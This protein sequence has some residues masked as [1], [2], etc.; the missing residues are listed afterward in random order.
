VRGVPG[1]GKSVFAAST[2]K[3]LADTQDSEGRKAPVLFFFFRQIVEKNRDPKYLVR[4]WA[5]QLL[6]FS[7]VLKETLGQL[8]NES[9]VNGIEMTQLWGGLVAALKGTD[10]VYCVAD[11]LDEMDDQHA[12]FVQKLRELGMQNPKSIKVLLTSRPVPRIEAQLRH[13][14]VEA[15]RLEPAQIYPDIISYVDSRL[16]T[17]E[18][19]VSHEKE[20]Q[21]KDAICERANGLFL[22]ARLTMDSLA[23]GL[24]EG[25][26]IE[27]TLP[28][29]LEQLPR[30]LKELYTK[31]LA[32]HSKRSGISQDQQFAI[33]Q[34]VTHS[35]RP[36]RLIELGSIIALLRRDPRASFK[37]GKD[38]VR[39]ACGRLLEILED[40]SVSVIHHSITE[41]AR[42]ESRR[43]EPGAFPVLDER[44]A[45]QMM[46]QVCLEYLDS[47][48]LPKSVQTSVEADTP[49]EEEQKKNDIDAED[50]HDDDS[51][52]PYDVLDSFDNR[53][54]R[55]RA[56][57]KKHR[58][59]QELRSSY[60]LIGYATE[61]LEYHIRNV[62]NGFHLLDSY[63]TPGKNAF[64]IWILVQ[65][66]PYRRGMLK[67][68]HI[69]ASLGLTEYAQ[70]LIDTGH[71]IDVAY[72]E[73]QTALSCAVEAGHVE[74]Q[75]ALS[76]AV[77]AGHVEVASLLLSKGANPNT[78]DRL[79]Y[80]PL[81]YAA[82]HN[83]VEVSKLLLA[84]GV[85]PK[86]EKTKCTPEYIV[87]QF[88][89]DRGETPLQ[90][91]CEKG[92]TEIIAQFVEVLDVDDA[93]RCL[94]WAVSSRKPDAVEAI[95][96]TGKARV[97]AFMNGSTALIKAAD[98][99]EPG[100]IEV[101]VRYGA[102]PNLRAEND[103]WHGEDSPTAEIK[104]ASES[105]VVPTAMHAFAGIKGNDVLWGEKKP[106]VE[107]MKFLVEAGGDANA[108][109]VGNHTPLHYSV[110]KRFT[111]WGE[112]GSDKTEEIVTELLLQHGADPNARCDGGATPLHKISPQRPK[113]VDILLR[114]G[115]DI[116]A[117][118]N[119]GSTPL[120]SIISS[121]GNGW[122]D[123]T[124]DH[125][126]ELS[127]KT[128]LKLLEYGA[129][130]T[131]EDHE[132]WTVL[133]HMFAG[134]DNFKNEELWKAFIKAGADLNKPN[135]DGKPPL[136]SI[137]NS[138][139]NSTENE[140]LFKMLVEAGL[141][142]NATDSTD[143]TVLFKLFDTY[144]VE[145]SA[146]QKLLDLGCSAQAR[147]QTGATLLHRCISA[148]ADFEIFKF[149]VEAGAEPVAVDD[150][151]NTIF[152]ELATIHP[153]RGFSTKMKTLVD[154]RVPTDSQ[155]KAGMTPLH[156]ACAT[157]GSNNSSSG[158]ERTED[159][160][161]SLLN[162]KLCP[163]S[164]FNA[165]DNIRAS[166][167]HYA[168]SLSEY[169]VGRLLRAGA[170][171]TLKTHEGLIP[172]HIA[173]RGRQSGVIALFVSEY[174][175]R[176]DIE[177]MVDGVDDNGRTALHYACRSGRP[178]SVSYLLSAGARH[179][180]RDKLGRTPLH[181]LTELPEENVLWTS[182]IG[183]FDAAGVT[184]GD[185][186][187]P[188]PSQAIES[189]YSDD[190]RTKDIIDMLEAAGADFQATFEHE[191]NPS[192]QW[193]W[194]CRQNLPRW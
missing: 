130:A 129:D 165:I 62:E 58:E 170:D 76:C 30:N 125:K 32:E 116:N 13:T 162:E 38:L 34:C 159:F 107:C 56:D 52:D 174:R 194:P 36:L 19:R 66:K 135:K 102:N 189:R 157:R 53:S 39:R 11:A 172:L 141:Q 124:G 67:P 60:P 2:V 106:G 81:H 175:K 139:H 43:G 111:M 42:D 28:T 160:L 120:L 187:R 121:I 69:A 1:S 188:R 137:K 158:R 193:T 105:E 178:E 109:T 7:G 104:Y 132:S 85:S 191:G 55:E 3:T 37:E 182:K 192:Q 177:M 114:Q 168:A 57:E 119:G 94:H 54:G 61:N 154:M 59:I 140:K 5:A 186:I 92:N 90:Y 8:S 77:E 10:K 21:V 118:N 148:E 35:T 50:D 16:R 40:E 65:W 9:G 29:S 161:G 91:A 12:P 185:V 48:A 46:L 98:R 150:D 167:I 79:G 152:H 44:E 45:Q 169:H 95:L 156:I 143:N 80:T 176:G 166:P 33:L 84:A 155:N 112:R 184:L 133:H 73:G 88:G 181:A 63:F 103:N 190:V 99:M 64:E 68:L 93:C 26:I 138:R 126:P 164:N 89:D 87:E 97:D 122:V 108:R 183:D 78:D 100:L 15:V 115:A 24:Q 113:L 151:G 171:P 134:I 18:P 20:V 144:N 27:D 49:K 153:T 142:I 163:I 110:K 14:V 128:L 25:S 180:I 173:A 22:Y 96:Q 70:H 123:V 23:E 117:R 82:M 83:R 6:P 31:M 47:C 75:T 17:L 149:L 74:V 72:G 41:F 51:Y 146:F 4:D 131:V 136:L 145:V 71:E 179:S 147:D 127:E 101:L 86:T